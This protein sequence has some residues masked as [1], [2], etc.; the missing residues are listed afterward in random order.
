MSNLAE[1]IL[2]DV[3]IRGRIYTGGRINTGGNCLD[4]LVLKKDV[5]AALT[6]ALDPAIAERAGEVV[7]ALRACANGIG[8]FKTQKGDFGL[9]DDAADL[10]TALLTANAALRAERDKWMERCGRERA[11]ASSH[12]IRAE[13]AEAQIAALTARVEGLTGALHN[14]VGML[15]CLVAESGRSI[16]WGQ[17]DP[18][19][20]GEWFE[21]EDLAQIKQARAALST[22]E[23]G[24]E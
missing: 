3:P 24:H 21:P 5:L 8:S 22:T 12:L 6:A 16:E 19:R 2:R 13:A 20:M 9:C 15:D 14:C 7:K 11:F 4:E 1:T 23:E 18:F 10:I 17:E